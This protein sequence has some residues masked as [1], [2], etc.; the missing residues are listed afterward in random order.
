[1]ECKHEWRLIRTGAGYLF[2][3]GTIWSPALY[4]CIFCCWE[5]KIGR[6]G[7]SEEGEPID[8]ITNP[9]P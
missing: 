5:R 9:N 6:T 1:M 3:S 4:Y 2:N 7:R 8:E